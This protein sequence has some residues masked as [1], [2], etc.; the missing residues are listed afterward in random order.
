LLTIFAWI[1]IYSII[2]FYLFRYSF[3]GATNFVSFKESYISMLTLLTTANFPD[4]MLPAY[5]KNFFTMFFFITY[6]LIGLYFL[7]NLLLAT[8]FNKFK[9]RLEQRINQN[10]AKRSDQI[11]KVF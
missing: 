6:L 9:G 3:E 1:F 8:V 2:G 11:E 7:L 5:Q 4:V 10:Q